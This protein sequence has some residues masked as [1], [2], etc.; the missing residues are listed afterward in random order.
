MAREQCVHCRGRCVGLVIGYDAIMKLNAHR[1][2]G[3]AIAAS[4]AFP[5]FARAQSVSTQRDQLGPLDVNEHWRN[6]PDALLP[7]AARPPD[8]RP[9]LQL[10]RWLED[11]RALADPA[12][13][14]DRFD[15]LK[16]VA[17]TKDGFAHLTLSGQLREDFVTS[18]SGPVSSGSDTY[19][20]HRLYLGADLHVGEARLFAEIANTAAPGKRAPLTTTD[21]DDL[22][23]QLLFAD[24]RLFVGP[25]QIIARIGRQELVYDT[26]QRFL[27]LRE[28]PNNRQAFDA[29]RIDLK[30]GMLTLSGF[31]GRPIVYRP[32]VFDDR[33]NASVRFSG[34]SLVRKSGRQTQSVY[35][36]GYANHASKIGSI[37]GV[38]RRTALGV[39]LA[40]KS[41]RIDYDLEAMRQTGSFAGSRIRA[42]A[43]GTIAGYTLDLPARPRIGAQVDLASGDRRA[44]DGVIGTFNPLF[45]NG[46]YITEAPVASYAN[47]LHLKTS[48]TLR[49]T[50][51]DA[52]SI[53]YAELARLSRGDVV[54]LPPLIPQ[55][56]TAAMNGV[57]IGGFLGATASHR[58]DSHLT[59]SADAAHFAASGALRTVGGHD[60]DYL[61][62]VLNLLF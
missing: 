40:G 55:Q 24:Y 38:E 16:Y 23:L 4:L 12:K 22:D 41:G 5:S 42:W 18:G 21:R 13:R 29:A 30:I 53:S 25:A 19:G 27:G 32:G 11:W 7:P 61:K 57:R 39:R 8:K 60:V 17:L 59:L 43:V 45:G 28:G 47:L 37:V 14:T 48:L 50:A 34:L 3:L 58:F 26:T 33:R 36:Y 1:W 15:P 44:G 51:S 49:P 20:L 35:L 62:V 10:T 56:A 2:K 54:Y 6:D 52:F 31:A 9:G 46:A